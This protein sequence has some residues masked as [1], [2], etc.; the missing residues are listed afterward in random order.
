MKNIFQAVPGMPWLEFVT[1][2]K[3]SEGAV[4]NT[5]FPLLKGI[6]HL[7]WYTFCL[8]KS[9][10]APCVLIDQTKSSGNPALSQESYICNVDE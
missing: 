7:R 10:S 1:L 4:R 8:D 2:E 9:T 5:E 3:M 6:C